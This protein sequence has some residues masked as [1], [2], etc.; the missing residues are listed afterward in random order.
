MLRRKKLLRRKKPRLTKSL[1]LPIYTDKTYVFFYAG[2]HVICQ[3]TWNMSYLRFYIWDS[4][5]TWT[6]NLYVNTL[7]DGRGCRDR[8]IAIECV[9]LIVV[10]SSKSLLYLDKPKLV[11]CNEYSYN[12]CDFSVLFV[13]TN[14]C[15]R[16][17]L[18]TNFSFRGQYISRSMSLTSCRRLLL[19]QNLKT[20]SP[21]IS[22]WQ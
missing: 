13:D 5:F 2:H 18:R 21:R 7:K 17:L 19:W 1:C 4:A 9:Q 11:F 16:F 6:G 8:I 20:M 14:V 22:V 15:G 12:S 3:V 10:T